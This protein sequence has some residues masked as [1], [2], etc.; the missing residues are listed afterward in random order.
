MNQIQIAFIGAIS[1]GIISLIVNVV[2]YYIKKNDK[3]KEEEQ[4]WYEEVGSILRELK[5]ASIQIDSGENIDE[6]FEKPNKGEVIKKIEEYNDQI[7]TFNSGHIPDGIESE[8]R[9][10]LR[11]L[12]G[13]INNPAGGSNNLQTTT[14][15]SD[16][17]YRES[18]DIQEK[19]QNKLE[20]Y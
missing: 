20:E 3:K 11:E 7:K 13:R 19:I 2:F 15:L 12:T 16:Y 14:D 10:S 8:I 1:G 17:I 18:D 9:S 4:Q 5:V 6:V